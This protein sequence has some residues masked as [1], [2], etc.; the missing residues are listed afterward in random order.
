MC[1]IPGTAL[2]SGDVVSAE[3]FLP[4][5]EAFS[6]SA[7][8]Q[9][10]RVNLQVDVA[11]GHYI[12]LNRVR[13]SQHWEDVKVSLPP[14]VVKDDPYFGKVAVTSDSFGVDVRLNPATGAETGV[15]VFVFHYQGCAEAGLCYPPQHRQFEISA[16][17]NSVHVSRD[18]RATGLGG[19]RAPTF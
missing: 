6:V 17:D 7:Q 15:A 3:A 2:G 14:G 11:P 10:D 1:G 9:G 12:Y 13:V 18:P 19:R 5:D 16:G 8:R 4:V